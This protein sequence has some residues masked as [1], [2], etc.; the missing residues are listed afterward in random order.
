MRPQGEGLGAGLPV[1]RMCALAQV[2]RA[3]YY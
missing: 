2:S 3:A 1:E